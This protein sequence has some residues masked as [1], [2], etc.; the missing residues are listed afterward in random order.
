MREFSPS[1][2]T[3]VRLPA[4]LVALAAMLAVL[5]PA[6]AGEL[7]PGAGQP[8]TA[9]VSGQYPEKPSDGFLAELD[10]LLRTVA[11]MRVIS[12]D[13]AD[14]LRRDFADFY[15]RN[16]ET[17]RQA[18]FEYAIP[19]VR[20][21]PPDDAGA[22]STDQAP[23]RPI[24]EILGT[25][26]VTEDGLP[27]VFRRMFAPAKEDGA[28][29]D[30]FVKEA[31]L[32][33]VK[34]GRFRNPDGTVDKRAVSESVQRDKGT[35]GII[36]AELEAMRRDGSGKRL[37]SAITAVAAYAERKSIVL[38]PVQARTGLVHM[39]TCI[40]AKPGADPSLYA[41]S[42]GRMMAWM[43]ERGQAAA[44]VQTSN[45]QTGEP[46][47]KH[48]LAP[49]DAKFAQKAYGPVFADAQANA[50]D[51]FWQR[52]FRLYA[53]VAAANEARLGAAESREL[54]TVEKAVGRTMK[55]VLSYA[56]QEPYEGRNASLSDVQAALDEARRLKAA[57]ENKA[58]PGLRTD[59][60]YADTMRGFDQVQAR[61]KLA[62]AK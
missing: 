42:C 24:H 12:R 60:G 33:L 48:V 29:F 38:A 2:G 59:T 32:V 57:L 16:P 46:G 44:E 34:K 9:T 11:G 28:H 15:E 43:G 20:P 54:L 39:Q 3:R 49:W 13:A 23:S 55:L 17:L 19:S 37:A 6:N 35:Y 18:G 27:E 14:G 56:R 31:Y 25:R 10:R 50:N 58:S 4:R 22:S 47:P 61:A 45:P 5:N 41:E 8:S 30:M 53:T 52:H 7:P 26:T 36:A 21:A 1:S 51:A 40:G 62:G